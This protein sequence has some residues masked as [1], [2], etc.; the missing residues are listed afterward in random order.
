M[1]GDDIYNFIVKLFP[2]CRSITGE[3]TRETLK[4]IKEHIP[5]RIYEVPSGTQVFDWTVPKEWNIRDAFILD[6]QGNKIVDFKE[7]NLHVMGY[8]TPINKD[9]SLSE[10]QQHLYSL[11]EQPMAI[12]Y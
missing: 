11:E 5:L 12:H 8:S 9:V 3:G 1:I 2:L 10:L 7:N 6:E 4:I